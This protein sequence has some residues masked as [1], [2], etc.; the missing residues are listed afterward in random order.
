[1]TEGLKSLKKTVN[2]LGEISRDPLLQRFFAELRA[3]QGLQ[4]ND[5]LIW[6]RAIT[7]KSHHFES[8]EPS[9]GHNEVLEF[10]GDR[11]LDLILADQLIRQ[12]PEASEGVLSKL[13]A[14][15]VSEQ[16]LFEIAMT[17]QLGMFLQLGE[18]EARSQ[19]AK[20]PRLLASAVEALVGA[21]Y[22]DLGFEATK[23]WVLQLFARALAEVSPDRPF[24]ED[25]KTRLQEWSQAKFRQT[26]V[27][28]VVRDEGPDHQK[29][30]VV[31]VWVQE[32]KLGEGSGRSKKLADQAAAR[33]A[34]TQIE[35]KA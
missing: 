22:I 25:Y 24:T 18:G 32:N 9:Q 16:P 7:H 28:K 27:Y 1:M 17:L 15:L 21:A 26:P 19:G 4:L 31:E 14:S 13:K 10:L 11:A 5:E 2:L 8:S 33:E 35:A 29:T 23:Q 12:F 6:A 30:F 34:L 20:K 3:E